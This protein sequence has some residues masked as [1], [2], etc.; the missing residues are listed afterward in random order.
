M[1]YTNLPIVKYRKEPG[2][3]LFTF[4]E[5]QT[6][7]PGDTVAFVVENG[8]VAKDFND[9]IRTD[10]STGKKQGKGKNPTDSGLVSR[11]G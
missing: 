3:D 6:E 9:G 8:A 11:G 5:W 4:S 10:V 1:G 2:I 7:D